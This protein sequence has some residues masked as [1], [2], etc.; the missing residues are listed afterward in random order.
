[1][2]RIAEQFLGK[3]GSGV[4][5]RLLGV[6]L[7]SESDG[8]TDLI[9]VTVEFDDGQIFEFG[10]AGDGSVAVRSPK[11][12]LRSPP[13][14]KLTTKELSALGPLK[15]ASFSRDVGRFSNRRC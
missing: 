8:A 1:M 6:I 12:T 9:E 2:N 13:G 5:R 10:C 14:F 7:T 3:A 11:S 4:V 15:A